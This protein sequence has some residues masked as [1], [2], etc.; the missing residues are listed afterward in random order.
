VLCPSEFTARELSRHGLRAPAV[1]ISNGVTDAFRP[2]PAGSGPSF[3]GRVMIISVGRLAAEKRHDLLIEAVRRSRHATRIQLVILGAGPRRQELERL[4][5]TLPNPI[6]FGF[7]PTEQLV[8]YYAAAALCVHASEVEVEGMAALEALACG[9]PCLVADSPKSA[10]PQFAIDERY[11][12][13]SGSRESL[14]ARLDALL[15]DPATLHADRTR[16]LALASRFSFE[17]SARR[18]EALYADVLLQPRR[19]PPTRSPS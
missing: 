6:V 11:L 3:D 7:L 2:I 15:D 8:P 9:T 13:T 4:G 16:A 10:T 14:V 19:V 5:A 1:V 12:F 17:E 18:L